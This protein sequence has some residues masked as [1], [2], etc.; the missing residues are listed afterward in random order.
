MRTPSDDPGDGNSFRIYT[1]ASLG[2]AIRHY[3]NESGLSQTEL[4]ERTG[5]NRTYLSNLERGQET[6]QLK[7]VLRLLRQL[8]LRLTI[9][10]ADG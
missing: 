3:R 5:L 4:A 10:K 1:P 9:E 7:R 6:E 2:A 8:G